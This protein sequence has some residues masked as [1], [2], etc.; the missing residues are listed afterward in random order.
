MLS[1]PASSTASSIHR[2]RDPIFLRQH[3]RD[4]SVY[5]SVTLKRSISIA[6][7]QINRTRSSGRKPRLSMKQFGEL[8]TY[9]ERLH[10]VIA[11]D[12]P[13]DA[14]KGDYLDQLTQ[15]LMRQKQIDA[16]TAVL[17]LPREKM[18]Q[19]QRL[20]KEQRARMKK[21]R[22][23]LGRNPLPEQLTEEQDRA[24][25]AALRKPGRIADVTGASVDDKDLQKL[26][27]GAWLND[28]VINFYG[29]LILMRADQA[30][31]KRTEAMAAAKDKPAEAAV[32]NA[33]KKNG[34]GKVQRPY[35]S[36]LDAFW[37]VHF[38]SSFFYNKLKDNGYAGVKRWTRRI[39]IFSKDIILFPI[40]LGNMH[41]TCGAINMRKHRFEYYDSMGTVN[42]RA[43]ELM[44]MYVT[45]EARDK[46][47]KEIDLRGWR[48]VFSDETPQQENGY[49][50]GVF[51]AQTLEQI[52]RRDPHT[53]IPL[54]APVFQWKDEG[55]DE[56]AERLHI[57]GADNGGGDEFDDD[58]DEYE[59]NFGQENMPYL[60]RRMAYEISS[61]QL[62]D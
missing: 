10:K 7:N 43:F 22:G 39:D 19:R 4:V 18:E 49:D 48:N 32:S 52:S 47:K 61:K 15:R 17:P 21:L 45:E 54:D 13:K 62:L 60:R 3:L 53:P 37:R 16:Q 57:N 24:A 2:K 25:T 50:C 29:Q 51:A 5:N 14:K 40:N 36:S 26:R 46:K 20:E 11:R 56:G 1:V 28:E 35:D 23:V 30:E 34:K 27:P 58:D 41:W 8:A 38:F 6:L 44:R 33:S 12:N 9:T 55:L 31:K 42:N 59:W